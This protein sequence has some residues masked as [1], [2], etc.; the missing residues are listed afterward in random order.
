MSPAVV[1]L[2]L[3][4]AL[5]AWL[6]RRAV[7]ERRTREAV[8]RGHY[9]LSLDLVC[10]ATFDGYFERVNPAWRELL[11][12]TPAELSSQPFL[13][14]VH[15]D[16]RARTQVEAARLADGTDTLG[17]RNRYRAADG[18]YL[19]LEWKARAVP[20]EGRIYATGREIT[21]QQEAEDELR[22]QSE[23]LERTVADQTRALQD[24]RLEVLQRLAIAS[25][26][27]DDDTHQHTERVGRTAALIALQL[28][29]SEET[30]AVMRHAA[31][32]HDI[33]K[34]GI[35][36]SILLKPGKL[37]PDEISLMQ[38]HTGI[39]ARILADGKFAVVRLAQEIALSHH[40]RWDGTG[41]P[42][43]LYREAIPLSGRIVAVADVFDALTHDRPY[44]RAWSIDEAVAEI[45]RLSAY[46][47]DPEAAYA[48]AALDHDRLLEPVERY[49]VELPPPPLAT[50]AGSEVRAPVARSVPAF[51]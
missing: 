26:Y 48:F 19:W 40:E 24:A 18:T 16:D 39:G 46:H 42:N 30:A 44:K 49:D 11:G 31:P 1:L 28:G 23:L 50:P 21:I 38:E 33:G 15:P 14:F 6:I 22:V 2:A 5:C 3:P 45:Y 13:D 35:P 8:L 25:E 41:Y 47:F 29:L 12:Y 32:L 9:D 51:A 37:S 34:V 36:D 4:I 10:T 17:F 43:G 20:E 27:R 7:N